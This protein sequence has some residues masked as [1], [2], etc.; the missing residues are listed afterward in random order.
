MRLRE[1]WRAY[2]PSKG[3]W[4]WSCAASVL[5]TVVL[6]FGWGG[7]MTAGSARHLIDNARQ[8]TRDRLAAAICVKRFEAAPN[9]AARLATLA[10]TGAWE[11]ADFIAKSG[12]LDLPGIDGPLSDAAAICAEKLLATRPAAAPSP[13]P[14]STQ[15]SAG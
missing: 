11:Q 5:A 1:H 3:M 15:A 2:Q 4:L 9:A 7:W 13:R 8:D 12:W 14:A 6:G 10:K